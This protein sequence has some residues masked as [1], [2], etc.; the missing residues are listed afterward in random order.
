M[1]E[2]IKEA[3]RNPDLPFSHV[4]R[5]FGVSRQY[6]HQVA[7]QLGIVGRQRQR[8]RKQTWENQERLAREKRR[9]SR[10]WAQVDKNGPTSSDSIGPCWLWL[11]HALPT[12]YGVLSWRG[13]QSY[14]HR[15]S[16][17]LHFGEI[18]EGMHVCHRCDNPQ[19]VRPFHLFLG[20]P[21]EN[22]MDAVIK[23][24]KQWR[25]GIRGFI[26]YPLTKS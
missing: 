8:E 20:T 7:Q 22:H 15:I 13:K 25:K 16:Y 23:G 11:G 19:C 26:K 18:S 10:F 1:I 2:Q 5:K 17:E 3:L 12:G 6:V 24:R 21:K 4:A 9:I 14:S